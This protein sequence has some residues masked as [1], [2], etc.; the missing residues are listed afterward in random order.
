MSLKEN[1]KIFRKI[2]KGTKLFSFQS[3]KKSENLI[4]IVMGILKQIF[5]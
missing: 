5:T 4:K 2:Q 3:R 1:F